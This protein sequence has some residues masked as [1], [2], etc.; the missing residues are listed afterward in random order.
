MSAITSQSLDTGLRFLPEPVR[1]ELSPRAGRRATRLFKQLTGR[2]FCQSELP[3]WFL[4][5]F[6]TGRLASSAKYRKGSFLRRTSAKP[7]CNRHGPPRMVAQ[8]TIRC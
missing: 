4:Q 1:P 6:I 3:A 8:G 5:L 7:L 2:R